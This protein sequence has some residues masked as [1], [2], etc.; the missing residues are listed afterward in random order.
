MK[1]QTSGR[2]GLVTDKGQRVK[3]D[4]ITWKA[5]EGEGESGRV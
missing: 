4:D 5:E 3:D 2:E 1:N